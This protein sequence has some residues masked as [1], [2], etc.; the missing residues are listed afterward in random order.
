MYI[1]EVFR[2][3]VISYWHCCRHFWFIFNLWN[4]K[5]PP[6]FLPRHS[7][8]LLS[9]FF[10]ASSSSFCSV[11]LFV[12]LLLRRFPFSLF[13]SFVC[14][15]GDMR[16][17]QELRTHISRLCAYVSIQYIHRYTRIFML[18]VCELHNIY[19]KKY[20]FKKQTSCHC[21]TAKSKRCRKLEIKEK[22]CSTEIER[23]KKNI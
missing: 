11:L 6:S 7:F 23:S 1:P 5:F 15:V 14:L 3:V 12:I 19:I 18:Y 16:A 2:S 20:R 13:R 4:I 17:R 8:P 10:C 22:K 21:Q 9:T